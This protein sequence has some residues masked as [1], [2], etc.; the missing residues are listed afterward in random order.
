MRWM[1]CRTVAR[2]DL[3]T[4][5]AG[6]MATVEIWDTGAGI[7]EGLQSRVFEPFFYD[8]GSRAAGWGWGSTRR[9]AS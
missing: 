6:E 7:P 3:S 4:R 9:N 8:Q 1:P 5:L 2:C